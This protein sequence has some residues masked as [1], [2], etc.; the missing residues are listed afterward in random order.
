MPWADVTTSLLHRPFFLSNFKYLTQRLQQ[1]IH[2]TPIVLYPV[3]LHSKCGRVFTTF[4]PVAQSVE[5]LTFNQWV[6][7][8]NPSRLR[9][10]HSPFRARGHCPLSCWSHSLS[11]VAPKG[12]KEDSPL[13]FSPAIRRSFNEVGIFTP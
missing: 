5:Q 4:G 6:D 13:Y 1:Y 9:I 12:A 3:Y 2:N 10:S 11:S 7:G 8:S